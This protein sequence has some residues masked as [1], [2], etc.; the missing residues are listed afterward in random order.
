VPSQEE[1]L[2]NGINMAEMD[3]I[4]LQKTKELTLY[5]IELEKKV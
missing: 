2:E 1:V 3:A 5:V 4:L